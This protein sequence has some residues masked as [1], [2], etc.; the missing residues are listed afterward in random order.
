M[1]KKIKNSEMMVIP[2]GSHCVQ[3]D[4]PEMVN[5]KIETFLKS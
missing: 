4:F 2:Y 1:N 5:L 3:L